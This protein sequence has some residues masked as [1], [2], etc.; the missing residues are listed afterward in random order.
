[1]QHLVFLFLV[2][3]AAVP[4]PSR[5]Q[6]GVLGGGDF[7]GKGGSYVEQMREA[8]KLEAA[9]KFGEAKALYRTVTTN[10]GSVRQA[11][12]G[13][14]RLHLRVGDYRAARLAFGRAIAAN[15]RL[16]SN[17]VQRG[18]AYTGEGDLKR[19]MSD[20]DTAIAL[21]P[22]LPDGYFRRAQ[23]FEILG[24]SERAHADRVR[25]IELTP[26]DPQAIAELSHL[27][28]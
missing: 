17:Y 13:L 19:A 20:F 27:D 5:A 15:K 6:L 3:L 2:M 18:I 24:D 1:M 12:E 21:D 4:T 9:G 26:D 23:L 14:G 28:Y 16:S 25:G 11:W 8:E 22:A 7:S 10:I